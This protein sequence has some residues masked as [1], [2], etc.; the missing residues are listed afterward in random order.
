VVDDADISADE[1]ELDELSEPSADEAEELDE[2]SDPGDEEAGEEPVE[3]T[4]LPAVVDER[5]ELERRLTR[6]RRVAT[7]MDDQFELPLVGYRVG[8]DPLIG[9]IPGGGD[10]ASYLVSVYILLQAARLGVPPR[11]LVR[12]ATAIGIDLVVG[13]VPV[14]GDVADFV[15]KANRRSVAMILDH[16]GAV[17]DVRRPDGVSLPD[18]ASSIARKSTV[19]TWLTGLGLALILLALAAAPFVML[20]YWLRSP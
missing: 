3:E 6:L 15:Y 13:Y 17:A 20:W 7:L 4:S 5:G 8:L 12:I 9:L 2:P 11:V 1:E 19:V 16:F 18:D 14:A 10:W